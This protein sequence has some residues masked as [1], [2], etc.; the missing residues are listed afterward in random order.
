MHAS[1]IFGLSQQHII[2]S[3]SRVSCGKKPLCTPTA[4]MSLA[5]SAGHVHGLGD[6]DLLPRRTDSYRAA[7]HPG[8]SAHL[9]D[10]VTAELEA[11]KGTTD[12]E[13]GKAS[14]ADYVHPFDLPLTNPCRVWMYMSFSW[15]NPLFKVGAV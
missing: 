8:S 14:E 7:T 10:E 9:W 5:N 15:I 1:P 4:R 6:G 3:A 11:K 13:E 12:K 2:C